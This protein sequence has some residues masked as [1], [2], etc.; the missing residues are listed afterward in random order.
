M[1][2]YKNFNVARKSI[3]A[4]RMLKTYG[5]KKKKEQ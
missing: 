5:C 1:C 2:S 3:Y 4:P